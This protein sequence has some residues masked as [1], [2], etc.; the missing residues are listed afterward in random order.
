MFAC[1]QA[2][3]ADG[4]EITRAHIE[5][6]EEGYRL[7]ATYE[8]ELNHGLEDAIQ[9]GVQLYFTTQV[10]LTRPR[11]YWYDDKAVSERQTIRISY[12]VLTRQYQVAVLGS[13]QQSFATLED[14][15]VLIRRPSRWLIAPRGA[16]K[17]GESYNV[18]VRMYMDR[19]RLPKPIQVNAFSNSQWR[20]E[21]KD[22]KFQYR[23][24]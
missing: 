21:S 24:E 12:N 19:E 22:K 6:T 5:A 17:P 4:V 18:T 2:Q 15:M 9:H 20:L 11:W 10:E 16:L 23:A 8:F 1:A 7:A 13:M 3:A 14:A